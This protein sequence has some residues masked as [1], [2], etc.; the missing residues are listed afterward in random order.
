MQIDIEAIL[1]INAAAWYYKPV[2]SGFFNGG[3]IKQQLVIM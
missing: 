3:F 2:F 1:K